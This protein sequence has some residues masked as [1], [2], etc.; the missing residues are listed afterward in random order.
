[1]T[2]PI[3]IKRGMRVIFKPEWRDKGDHK[4]TFVAVTDANVVGSFDMSAI[5][6]MFGIRGIQSARAYMV[7]SAEPLLPVATITFLG[8]DKKGARCQMRRMLG[9]REL[10]VIVEVIALSTFRQLFRRYAKDCQAG[11]EL[12]SGVE[13]PERPAV[14]D[15]AL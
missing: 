10:S 15:A 9:D 4:Y 14:K 13:F 2:E 3:A 6:N 8:L 11:D 7:E 5:E 12:R 1:M